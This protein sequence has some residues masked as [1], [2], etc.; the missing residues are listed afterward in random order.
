MSQKPAVLNQPVFVSLMLTPNSLGSGRS[1]VNLNIRRAMLD[2]DSDEV[3][4]QLRDD[5]AH[6]FLDDAAPRQ[7]DDGARVLGLAG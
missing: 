1:S 2:V 5:R 7:R 4:R 6:R 3:A